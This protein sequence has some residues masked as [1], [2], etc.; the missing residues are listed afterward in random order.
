MYACMDLIVKFLPSL[1]N[2]F[3][4]GIR[5]LKFSDN[6]I[7][8]GSGGGNLFFYDLRLAKYV[9]IVDTTISYTEELYCLKTTNGWVVS[10][11]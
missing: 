1:D 4:I 2:C 9:S 5:S 10:T 8:V 7:S 3:S 11:T 6:L